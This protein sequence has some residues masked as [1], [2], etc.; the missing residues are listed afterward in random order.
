ML[1]LNLKADLEPGVSAAGFYLG[2]SYNEII[3]AIGFVRWI[4]PGD[5]VREVL[6]LNKG[7]V[8]VRKKIGRSDE[9]IVTLT[10]LNDVVF[11]AFGKSQVLY[12][13]VVGYGYV[14]TFN[15]VKIGDDLRALEDGFEIDFNDADDEFL[16]LADNDYVCWISFT[17][18]YR[19]SLVKAPRQLIRHVSIHD[20][21]LA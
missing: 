9:V 6:P 10:Y 8:G 12:Q 3:A 21:E 17:T 7:W 19:S 2:E 18:D 14:G 15:G 5:D 16:I 1:K 13:I 20:W 11:L 4:E